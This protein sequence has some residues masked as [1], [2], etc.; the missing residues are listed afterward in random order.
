MSAPLPSGP[1]RW[2]FASLLFVAA[3]ASINAAGSP[4]VPPPA[5]PDADT[6]GSDDESER[7]DPDDPAPPDPQAAP[8]P[9]A[10]PGPA[11][12]EK[13]RTLRFKYQDGRC[14]DGKETGHNRRH[15][16]ACG[17][18]NRIPRRLASLDGVDLRGSRSFYF[19]FN[20]RGGARLRADHAAWTMTH[21]IR[22]RL[23]DSSFVEAE[24]IGL[25]STNSK[26]HRS[27]F[28]G[29]NL[30]GARFFYSDLRGASFE[31]AR[32]RAIIAVESNLRGCDFR[33][34]DLSDAELQLS[35][36]EGALFDDTTK[37]P[38]DRAE[39][40]RRGMLWRGP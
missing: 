15:F 5:A 16:G 31:R 32:L 4:S 22:S 24:L 13:K 36:L 28:T 12:A 1:R 34:A 3:A 17:Q 8:G 26:L 14:T 38:F 39:A 30:E 37:L 29:A 11:S 35:P 23:V 18:F 19:A 27:K 20:R 21:L 2:L 6:A 10:E 25:V 7:P 40:E 9:A 33:G